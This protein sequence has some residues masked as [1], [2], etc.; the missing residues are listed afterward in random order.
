MRVLLLG[1]GAV[2]IAALIVWRT[3]HGPEVWHSLADQPS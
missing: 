2:A 3:Q 1:A